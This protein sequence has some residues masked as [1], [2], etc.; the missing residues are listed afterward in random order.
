M[1]SNANGPAPRFVLG[2]ASMGYE[3][4]AEPV[5]GTIIKSAYAQLDT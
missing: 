5:T 1:P 3:G 2:V 4:K